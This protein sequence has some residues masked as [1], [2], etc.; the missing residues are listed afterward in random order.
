MIYNTEKK[1][2]VTEH[3]VS[4][5][6]ANHSRLKLDGEF[7]LQAKFIDRGTALVTEDVH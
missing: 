4:P 7:R 2:S 5:S 1:R 6:Y 3:F